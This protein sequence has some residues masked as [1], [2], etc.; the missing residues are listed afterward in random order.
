MHIKKL[1][2]R[3]LLFTSVISLLSVTACTSSFADMASPSQNWWDNYSDSEGFREALFELGTTPVELNADIKNTI[4]RGNNVNDPLFW[5]KRNL[6]IYPADNENAYNI[7]VTEIH[8]Q[9]KNRTG[10]N[11]RNG[12][13]LTRDFA[14]AG[15]NIKLM[16]GE[17]PQGVSCS[18]AT[19][20]GFAKENHM[21]DS[22][23]LKSASVNTYTLKQDGTILLACNDQD[24]TMPNV[25][26]AVNIEILEGGVKQ[27]FFIFGQSTQADW[28]TLSQSNSKSG[29]IFMFSG[30]SRMNVKTAIAKKSADTNMVHSMSQYL[31]MTIKDDS[32][33][34]FDGTDPLNQPSRGL[35]VATYN[36]CCYATGGQGFTAIGFNSKLADNTDWGDWHEFGHHNQQGWSWSALNEVTVNLY[37]V[38]NCTLLRGEA[39]TPS[40][41]SN[42]NI[43]ALD[44]STYAVGNFIAS[45]EHYNFDN[46][47]SGT[48]FKRATL[49]AQ[50]LFSYP[51]L[52]PQLGKAFREE[53]NYAKNRSNLDSS[54]ELKDW[55]VVNTSKYSKNDLREFYDHWGLT[56]SS[57]ASD[58]VNAMKLPKP[59]QPAQT[60]EITLNSDYS[61]SYATTTMVDP[62]AKNIGFV[63]PTSAQGPTSLVWSKSGDTQFY[64]DVTDSQQRAFRVKLH[65]KKSVGQ[66]ANYTLNSAANC[67]SGSTSFLRFDFRKEDNT[68]LP[69]GTYHGTTHLSGRDWH[70][71][72]WA[73][74]IKINLNIV[75]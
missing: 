73:S 54:Q 8:S 51:E 14:T 36:D 28:K 61:S 20:V 34:G 21:L 64:A 1:S 4:A 42:S 31:A 46:S 55:F 44:W 10:A 74:E 53:Y 45:G 62:V 26:K 38:A 17:M 69:A 40:C 35:I 7:P 47:G 22:Q 66:C 68:Q 12:Y 57:Q 67:V 29:Q 58:A 27:P 11:G 2:K 41:H 32:L 9:G 23:G 49:F 72:T 43:K 71:P 18:I 48:E 60:Q 56:Y 5:L 37:S 52:Y 19:G 6:D 13:F 16:V 30:R 63:L 25:D 39:P 59:Y 75:K 70:K 24:I 15:Q 33:N 65:G 3:N 50:L